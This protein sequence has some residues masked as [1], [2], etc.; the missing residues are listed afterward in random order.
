MRVAYREDGEFRRTNG[1]AQCPYLTD[2]KEY[3]VEEVVEIDGEQYYMIVDDDPSS[4]DDA[5][6]YLAVLFEPV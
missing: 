3:D 4:A 2:G 5:E 1:F 6:P